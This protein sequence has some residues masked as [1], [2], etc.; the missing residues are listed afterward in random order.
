[1]NG[2]YKNNLLLQLLKLLGAFIVSWFL[3]VCIFAASTT[4][5]EI[6]EKYN[7]PMV[8][9]AI[10]LSFAVNIIID[11]NAIARLKSAISKSKAD[12]ESVNETSAALID[13]AERVADKYRNAET[14]LYGKFARAREGGAKIRTSKDFKAVIESYPELKSNVHTQKLLSQIETTENAKLNAKMTYTDAAAKYNAKIHSFP[15]ALLR[16]ICK[17]EDVNIEA[18]LSKDE[19]VSDEDLGI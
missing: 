11:F 18:G 7:L 16:G 6:P 8:I 9:I 14:E 17:W 5:D 3:M 13:K 4:G 10:F 1:M 2:N 12:I 15:V 19:M